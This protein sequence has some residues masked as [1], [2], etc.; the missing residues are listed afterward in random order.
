MDEEHDASYKQES[1]PRYLTSQIARKRG[2]YHHCP[3][4]LG[5]AT[6]S[7]ESYSR[8]LKGIYHLCELP[9]RIT[10]NELPEIELIAMV[11]EM[12]HRR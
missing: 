9:E 5:S 4:I 3:V 11:E 10:Q 1:P 2:Q 6:P 8:A 12:K 7:L